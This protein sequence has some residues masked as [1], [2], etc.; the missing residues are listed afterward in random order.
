MRSKLSITGVNL[1]NDQPFVPTTVD[2]Y[3]EMVHNPEARQ[4]LTRLREIIRDEAP[5]AEEL[6][7]YRIPLY[8]LNGMLI[9][10]AAF[11]NHCSL[12]PGHTVRD[13]EDQLKDF[14]IS[15]GTIQF[16]PNNPVPEE[17][18]R[19]IVRARKLEN[20]EALDSKR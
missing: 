2:E 14:K 8:K 1:R 4:A 12:F 20:L 11:K 17:L 13:F 3:I 6:I 7:S 10:F 18:V 9:G 15:K 5:E 19:A 16:K